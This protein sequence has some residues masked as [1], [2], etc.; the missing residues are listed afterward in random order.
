M[1][2]VNLKSS[3]LAATLAILATVASAQVKAALKADIPFSFQVGS[4]G[5]LPAGEYQIS[6][7][8]S[9]WRFINTDASKQTFTLATADVQGNANDT[10]HLAFEC[11]ANHCT[12]SRVVPGGGDIGGY[13]SAPKRNKS[14]AGEL[15]RVVVVPATVLA[16]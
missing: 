6:R 9:A 5:M 1:K 15:A 2:N 7:N 3:A 4:Y 13:W 11:R 8:G 10:P 12:L 14:D 16:R